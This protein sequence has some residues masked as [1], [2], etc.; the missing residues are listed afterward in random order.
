MVTSFCL[1]VVYV[2]VE[3]NAYKLRDVSVYA[4]YTDGEEK[5][6]QS[7]FSFKLYFLHGVYFYFLTAQNL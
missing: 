2:N 6:T 5:T 4:R 1:L 3:I 7:E